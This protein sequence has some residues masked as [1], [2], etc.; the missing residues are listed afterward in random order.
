MKCPMC[1]LENEDGVLFCE[2]CKADLEAVPSA[3]AA[4]DPQI[5]PPP[6][7]HEPVTLEPVTPSPAMPSPPPISTPIAAAPFHAA[8]TPPPIQP[9]D[10][11]TS[12]YPA[13]SAPGP[14]AA[15]TSL[16]APT[17]PTGESL[18]PPAASASREPP[19]TVTSA[20]GPAGAAPPGG[21]VGSSSL[22]APAAAPT[23][24]T[25]AAATPSPSAAST[26]KVTPVASGAP[27]PPPSP[28]V[29]AT[30]QLLV[31]RG[32]RPDV[33]YPI[34]PGPN[35][36]GRTDEKPVDIDLEDQESPDRIWSSR[37]HA[38]ITFENNKLV[39]E[40]LNSLNG[41]FVNRTR[42]HPGEKRELH[43]NDIIQIGTV[44]LKVVAE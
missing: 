17:T 24:D 13:V 15:A 6:P 4:I 32:Q 14:L 3:A 40:D 22:G 9:D 38:V 18:V 20:N 44:H 30:V 43:A 8:V 27:A 10:F 19:A 36:I 12:D 5:V 25:S 33:R 2:H 23:I 31:V 39:I 28:S 7:A 26:L 41:T 37:Q 42:V 16:P 11:S 34:F 35:Y 21:S 29:N 1:G